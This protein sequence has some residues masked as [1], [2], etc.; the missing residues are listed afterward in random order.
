MNKPK[1]INLFDQKKF[2]AVIKV[3]MSN[4]VANIAK[5]T[6]NHLQKMAEEAGIEGDE[7]IAFAASELV[8]NPEELHSFFKK[9]FGIK[10]E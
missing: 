4:V 10:G 3:Q 1:T 5:S 7:V 2:R 6:L 8:E 9:F